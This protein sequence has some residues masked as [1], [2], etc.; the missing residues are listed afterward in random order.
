MPLREMSKS[1]SC[2][3]DEKSFSNKIIWLRLE[4]C[5]FQVKGISYEILSSASS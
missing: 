5:P 4:L 2:F 3:M 1:Y